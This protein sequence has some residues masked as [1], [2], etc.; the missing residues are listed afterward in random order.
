MATEIS[1]PYPPYD[2]TDREC[3]A[4]ETVTKRWPVILTGIIDNIYRFNHNLAT[5][6]ADGATVHEARI[7]E[8]KD[9]ISLKSKL[10]YE[11]GRDKPLELIVDGGMSIYEYNRGVDRLAKE[12]SNT[13][14]TAP[15]LF[16]ECYL[17]RFIRTFFSCTIHWQDYDPFF[18]Q[19]E[20]T[21]K[22]SGDAVYQLA[23]TMSEFSSEL[24]QESGPDYALLK[25][26]FEEMV[27]MCLWGNATDLSLLPLLSHADIQAL[28]SSKH[29]AKYVL[30]DDTRSVWEHVKTMKDGRLDIVLDNA[31][32]EL[33]TDLVFA[34]FLIT[35]TPFVSKVTFH[36]KLIPWFV[37]DVTPPDFRSLFDNLLTSPSTFFTSPSPPSEA[38]EKRLREMAL[39]W[40]SYVDSGV[41]TLARVEQGGE[42]W[43]SPGSYW[44]LGTT[45]KRVLGILKESDLVIFKGDLNYRK[46]TGDVKWPTTTPFST[47]IG[48]IK[49]EF[50]LL[51]LRTCKADVVVGLEEGVA[52]RLDA[53]ESEKGWRI[54]GKYGLISF[55]PKE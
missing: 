21:F 45:Q 33:F 7:A 54:N 10:K 53:D 12:G 3:F 15:W 11:M 23:Q 26:I 13:W 55:S 48:P 37:S 28:Q 30:R 1:F 17:Y 47:A 14:F 16:A 20:D 49:G 8:G 25:P 6:T 19:K 4:Y 27:L 39:R 46:L 24:R 34:D 32:F 43:V 50:A 52:G 36:A 2:P 51:S 44:E 18:E 35:F 22:S 5:S 31:G 42:F 40:K 9:I 41:F 38:Q 29:G